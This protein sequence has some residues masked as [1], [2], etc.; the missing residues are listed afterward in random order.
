MDIKSFNLSVQGASHIKKNKECQD[1]SASYFDEDCAVCVVCD[2]HGGDDYMR[3]AFGSKFAS[4]ITLENIKGFMKSVDAE[5]M[6]INS[7]G[8]LK[9]LEASIISGWNEAVNKHFKENP[10]SKEELIMVSER[11]RKKYT[12]QRRIESAYGTTV[13]GAAMNDK[14][15]IGIHIGDG[16]CVAVNPQ[17]RFLQPIPWDDKCFL[18]ATTSICDS[19]AL[20][21]FRSFYSEKLPIAV[22]VGSDGIDD[23]FKGNEQLHKLY[24]TVLYS[25][26]TSEFDEAVGELEDYLPRLS[27]KGSGDDMSV[28]A[29]IDISK[30]NQIPSV[31]NYD[32]EKEKAHVKAA[33]REAAEKA[34]AER[35][36]VMEERRRQQIKRAQA[37]GMAVCQGCGN[38]VE[39]TAR[40][41]SKCGICL[42][43][44]TA[45]VKEN[46]LNEEAIKKDEMHLEK[47]EQAN[48]ISESIGIEEICAVKI[49]EIDE[50]CVLENETSEE[51]HEN[52]GNEIEVCEDEI[53]ADSEGSDDFEAE[54]IQ[55]IE[56]FEEETSEQASVQEVTEN[57]DVDANVCGDD[58]SDSDE[59]KTEDLEEI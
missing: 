9:Q 25:F 12:E 53:S 1:A 56:V 35:I 47:A 50:K 58:F 6:R 42:I 5:E 21:N 45:P 46:N 20:E 24:N 8:L 43:A 44:E 41:C 55:I 52:I 4:K 17:G 10:F 14:F 13:I 34:E 15:W 37:L 38:L 29:I 22:F 28:S 39:K 16:K 49:N 2:G 54:E 18:N 33:K 27:A 40:F 23:C 3:S 7:K 31:R 36:R 11:A 51:H 30:L 26:M 48:D 32:T 59:L 57:D 19:H